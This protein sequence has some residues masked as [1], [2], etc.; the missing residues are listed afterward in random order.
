MLSRL[1]LLLPCLLLRAGDD[2]EVL[3]HIDS[4]NRSMA[5]KQFQEAVSDL[6]PAVRLAKSPG[7]SKEEL[8]VLLND[9]GYAYRRLGRCQDAI[10]VL[11]EEMQGWDRRQIPLDQARVGGTNLLQSYLDC[12]D[13]KSAA[14][15]WTRTLAP[16]AAKLDPLNPGL[17]ALLAADALVQCVRKHYPESEKL[18]TRAI[19]IW[20]RQRGSNRDGISTARSNRA[21]ARAYLGRMDAAVRDADESLDE[22]RSANGLDAPVRAVVLNNIAVVYL[23][24]RQFDQAADCLAEAIAIL[25]RTPVPSAPEILANFALLLRRTGRLKEAKSA[26]LHAQELASERVRASIGQTID[27][28]EFNPFW[29]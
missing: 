25:N 20:E 21:V 11:A 9:L 4:A 16:M 28:T 27:A 1:V 12:G 5:R 26:Q 23:M 13:R 17:A 22:L 24:H 10:G 18:W 19:V 29:K 14:R 3:R 2:S 7:A 15:L 6:L 8:G